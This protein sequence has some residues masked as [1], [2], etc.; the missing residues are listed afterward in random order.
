[1]SWI[2]DAIHAINPLYSLSGF[3]VG[4]LVGFTGVGGGSLMTPI[5]ILFFNIAPAVAV[6]TDLL[7]ASISKAFGVVLLEA[8]ASGTPVVAADNVGFRQV[9]RGD[10]PGRFV[11]PHDPAELARGIAEV[12]DDPARAEEIGCQ[13]RIAVAEEFDWPRVTDRIEA[14]YNEVLDSKKPG[15]TRHAAPTG[16]TA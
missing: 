15:A 6:G 7:Y 4:C 11:P 10:V 2:F 13:G 12:L 3:F 16:G 1:M 9:I 5:L 14:I 8:L